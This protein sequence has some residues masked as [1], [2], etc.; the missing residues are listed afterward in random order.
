MKKMMM[1]A[2]LS[3]VVLVGASGSVLAA[4]GG[5]EGPGGPGTG[6]GEKVVTH[7]FYNKK[8][9]LLY[10]IDYYGEKGLPVAVRTTVK[11]EYYDYSIIS[12]EEVK[13]QGRHIYLVDM[14]DAATIKTVRVEDGEMELV[15]SLVRGDVGL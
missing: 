6:A 5:R 7:N 9:R 3:G 13:V 1:I 4:V 2:L 8:G 12:V 11:S 10:T 14:E 15:R